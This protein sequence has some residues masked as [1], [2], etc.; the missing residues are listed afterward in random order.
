MSK[1]LGENLIRLRKQKGQTQKAVS[2]AIE[3]KHGTYTSWERG[4]ANPGIESLKKLSKHFGVLVDDLVCNDSWFPVSVTPPYDEND[5]PCS[6]RV[7]VCIDMHGS[8]T[9]ALAQFVSD[10]H[11]WVN[12]SDVTEFVTHWRPT[13]Q[14]PR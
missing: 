14:L 3:S 6:V 1:K 12:N 4:L 8:K 13:P 9:D 11:Y 5:H 7:W 10:G 2:E